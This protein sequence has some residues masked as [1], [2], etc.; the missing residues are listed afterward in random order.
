MVKTINEILMAKMIASGD[1]EANVI[2]PMVTAT[3][4][5]TIAMLRV[6][7]VSYTHLDVSTRPPLLRF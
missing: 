2:F 4:V 6:W 5:V 7:P 3:T 1:A